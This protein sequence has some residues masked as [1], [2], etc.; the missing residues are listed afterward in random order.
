MGNLTIVTM[1]QHTRLLCDTF[2]ITTSIWVLPYCTTPCT[3]GKYTNAYLGT[4]KMRGWMLE[5]YTPP[6]MSFTSFLKDQ[7]FAD[8]HTP[9]IDRVMVW[10]QFNCQTFGAKVFPRT[11]N[12]GLQVKSTSVIIS[13]VNTIQHRTVCSWANIECPWTFLLAWLHFKSPSPRRLSSL[14]LLR[15]VSLVNNQAK[16]TYMV[17]HS[18]VGF[19][20][21]IEWQAKPTLDL[22]VCLFAFLLHHLE[23]CPGCNELIEYKSVVNNLAKPSYSAAQYKQD[24][25][26]KALELTLND[27]PPQPWTF[28]FAFT[29]PSHSLTSPSTTIWSLC[30]TVANHFD[31]D[32]KDDDCFDHKDGNYL[33]YKDYNNFDRKNDNYFDQKNNDD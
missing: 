14:Q 3:V 9:R 29:S 21:N 26:I 16:P 33:D 6:Y 7:I 8:D 25:T 28:L 22:P 18:T 13:I 11:K 1:L 27:R 30:W 10:Q 24:T 20:A 19:W 4:D 31:W 2:D 23:C 5:N 12:F 17:Q 15:Y 32:Y